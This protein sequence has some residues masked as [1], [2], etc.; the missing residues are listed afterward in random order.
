MGKL[1]CALI[2]VALFFVACG[3]DG[4]SSFDLKKIVF[5]GYQSSSSKGV[6]YVMNEDGSNVVNLTNTSDISEIC[7]TWSPNGE[8]IYFLRFESSKY[9]LYV[10]N[11]DGGS[12]TKVTDQHVLGMDYD[13]SPDGSRIAFRSRDGDN[14]I[15]VVNSDGTSLI[16]LTNNSDNDSW[17][18][19]S[20]DGQSIAYVIY[21]NSIGRDLCKMNHDSTN[22]SFVTE[23]GDVAE[24]K[25]EWSPDGSKIAFTRYN[26]F[27]GSD[28]YE[29]FT[30][31][32]N[33][34]NI[35]NISNNK[36]NDLYPHWSKDGNKIA[37]V[38]E[39][40]DN[41][42]IYLWSG[43]S[44]VTRLTDSTAR[45]AEHSWSSDGKKILF[46][47]E[48][49]VPGKGQIYVMNAD[50]SNQTRLSIDDTMKHQSPKWQP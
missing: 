38:S 6:I 2:L 22:S 14:E 8:K 47:S 26:N 20:P 7:P 29:L 9:F 41:F 37:F 24:Y 19:W 44:I 17:P 1:K 46:I 31:Q 4:D 43:S 11:K 23:S 34:S 45:D 48:R 27:W 3:G 32:S 15:Y 13:V 35:D 36:N 21:R 30:I 33:G 50:G 49:D 10:I 5:V 39:R 25:P 18:S 12:A 28:N 40:D 16:Q 42:N